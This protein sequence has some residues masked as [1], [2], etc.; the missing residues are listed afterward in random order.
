MQ[1]VGARFAAV[2]PR[3]LARPVAPSHRRGKSVQ[4][5]IAAVRP[6]AQSHRHAPRTAA[7]HGHHEVAAHVRPVDVHRGRFAAGRQNRHNRVHHDHHHEIHRGPDRK[8]GAYASGGDKNNG[9]RGRRRQ[10]TTT[11]AGQ[12]V[13]RGDGRRRTRGFAA[14]C[15]RKRPSSPTATAAIDDGRDRYQRS[16]KIQIRQIRTRWLRQILFQQK[17]KAQQ[18]ATAQV[19]RRYRRRDGQV[20]YDAA[21]MKSMVIIIIVVIFINSGQNYSPAA[22]GL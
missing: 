7:R 11:A 2:A 9:R 22:P 12:Q 5:H 17:A 21:V 10:G 8:G 4:F 18:R 20:R 15:R 1:N 19:C 3:A 14:Y 16:G 6:R 13:V